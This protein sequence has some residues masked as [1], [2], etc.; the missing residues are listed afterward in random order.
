MYH[1]YRRKNPK[2][3]Q[4]ILIQQGFNPDNNGSMADLIGKCERAE[5]NKNVELGDKCS[6][7]STN[8]SDSSDN[9]KRSSRS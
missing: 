3:H 2:L 6:Q 8:A 1:H 7:R 9:E 4:S 5:I